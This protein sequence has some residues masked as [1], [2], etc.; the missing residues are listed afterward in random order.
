MSQFVKMIVNDVETKIPMKDDVSFSDVMSGINTG[1]SMCYDETG[2]YLPEVLEFAIKYA[3]ISTLTEIDLGEDVNSAYKVI[4]NI[5]YVPGSDAEYI[6]IGIRNS[7]E[8]HTAMTSATICGAGA[9]EISEQIQ[10]I[11]DQ[12]NQVLKLANSLLQE[13]MKE[14]QRNKDIDPKDIMRVLQ[15]LKVPN[16]DLVHAILDYNKEKSA[17][18]SSIKKNA[19][20]SVKKEIVK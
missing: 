11:T 2:K 15:N 19:T 4:R 14:V 5:D 9:A 16:A 6:E 18:P 3:Q 13:T 1:V 7:V 20:K 17:V 12:F 10:E 8:H